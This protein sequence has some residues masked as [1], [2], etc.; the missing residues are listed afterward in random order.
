MFR[1]LILNYTL[2]QISLATNQAIVK[3]KKKNAQKVLIK[4]TDTIEP[5][6]IFFITYANQYEVI[7]SEMNLSCYK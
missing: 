2:M 4:H 5:T 7:T 6:E 3:S 1:Y